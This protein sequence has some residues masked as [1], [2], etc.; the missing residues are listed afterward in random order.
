MGIVLIVYLI[1]AKC[2][3]EKEN[4]VRIML[5]LPIV[6]ICYS[7]VSDGRIVIDYMLKGEMKRYENIDPISNTLE[8]YGYTFRMDKELYY[9]TDYDEEW[10]E[11]LLGLQ[12]RIGKNKLINISYD[13]WDSI[14]KNSPLFVI[15]RNIYANNDTDIMDS[16][17]D[18]YSPISATSQFILYKY[19]G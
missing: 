3:L 10:N 13:D 9:L 11:Y 5:F 12:F 18:V 7:W 15:K 4:V 6:I 1:I 8:E 14:L 2:K 17:A 19:N 16:F